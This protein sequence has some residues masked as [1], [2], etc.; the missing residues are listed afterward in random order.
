MAKIKA[1][2][3]AEQV[4]HLN[5]WQQAGIVHPVTCA[6][7]HNGERDLIA[8]ES[9]WECPTCEYTQD[10]CHDYMSDGSLLAAHKKNLEKIRTGSILPEE[11]DDAV[12]GDE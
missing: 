11:H 3:T 6:N 8:T 5:E 1:P 10:W 4:K 7:N 12:N 2:W 9:G